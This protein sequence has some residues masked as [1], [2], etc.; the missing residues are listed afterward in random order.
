MEN[1]TNYSGPGS[2]PLGSTNLPNATLVLVFGILSIAL[3]FCYGIFGLAFGIVALILAKKDKDLYQANPGMYSESSF[4][5]LNAGRICAI[6]GMCLSALYLILI[7]V[8]IAIYGFAF[9][10]NP[11]LL[12][13]LQNA[14]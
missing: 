3:C 5:N 4:K 7:I 14:Q 11:G 10:S 13:Q 1:N 8:V 6:I 2:A 12:E 9:L